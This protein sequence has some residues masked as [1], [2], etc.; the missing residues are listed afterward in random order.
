MFLCAPARPCAAA[1]VGLAAT[2]SVTTVPFSRMAANSVSAPTMGF[3]LGLGTRGSSQASPCAKLVAIALFCQSNP[4]DNEP[5]CAR[6]GQCRR[7]PRPRL[8]SELNQVDSAHLTSGLPTQANI[9]SDMVMPA[10]SEPFIA[11]QT[12]R[13]I[14]GLTE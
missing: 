6:L 12:R 13:P 7:K 14:C 11:R 3:W 4:L 2:V 10:S 1:P 5:E 9:R 8:G